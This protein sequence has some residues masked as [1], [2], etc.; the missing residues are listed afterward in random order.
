M[1]QQKGTRLTST[2]SLST[3]DQESAQN[4]REPS[5]P[6]PDRQIH[7]ATE[8]PGGVAGT[9]SVFAHLERDLQGRDL[10]AYRGARKTGAR[11][12]LFWADPHR[13]QPLARLVTR[14]AAKGE[15]AVFEV[16]GP[17]DEP[18]ALIT[19]HPAMSG[20]RGRSRWT[21]QQ[22]DGLAAAGAKGNL[23][24]WYVWWLLSPLWLAIAVG[25][26][27]GGGD[28]ARMPRTVRLRTAG[29][30]ALS[31]RDVGSAYALKVR[32]EGWDPRVTAAL[33]ALI[34]SFDGWLGSP[35]DG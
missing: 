6:A 4:Q 26:L 11:G 28:I 23:F 8:G 12:F 25:S 10:Q 7:L 14:S 1:L 35:W 2:V 19:R 31:W 5:D 33:A 24:W 13:Q 9:P 22:A 34:D 32:A 29:E 27:V 18:L 20:G 17:A 16:L 3:A 30:K 21:V 15:P